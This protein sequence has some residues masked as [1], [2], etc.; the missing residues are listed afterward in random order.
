[1]AG[2]GRFAAILLTAATRQAA[3]FTE[4][5]LTAGSLHGSRPSPALR[6]SKVSKVPCH[7]G[8]KLT[9]GD[10]S[11]GCR[12]LR[13]P[14]PKRHSPGGDTSQTACLITVR[15]R[16]RLRT[17]LAWSLTAK[18]KRVAGTARSRRGEYT[19]AK[20]SPP[21]GGPLRSRDVRQSR[22]TGFVD[23]LANKNGQRDLSH[24]DRRSTL[25]HLAPTQMLADSRLPVAGAR[26]RSAGSS[27]QAR[28]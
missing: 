12:V 17:G 14:R 5:G 4:S 27:R 21:Q 8:S 2:F 13:H 9:F 15:V 16:K 1:M 11:C 25:T 22:P 20:R 7:G 10:L 26:E 3:V 6:L 23:G 18:A 28:G 24:E 19:R